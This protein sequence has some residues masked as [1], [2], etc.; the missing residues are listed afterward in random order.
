M[1]TAYNRASADKALQRA[2]WTAD[3]SVDLVGM[4]VGE[5]LTDRANAHPDRV[6]IIG[7]RHGTGEQ[8]RLTYEQLHQEACRVASALERLAERGS[9]IAIWAPNVI[10]WPIIQYGAALAGMVVVAINPAFRER[11]LQYALQ[12]SGSA[13]LLYADADR[14]YDMAAVVRRVAASLPDLTCISLSDS[15][16]WRAQYI[17]DDSLARNTTGDAGVVVMLQ[18]TSG[19]TGNPK[20]VLLRHASLV[21]VAKLTFEALSVPDAAVCLNP[22]PMFHT[23]GC[24][25][26]T[27]GPLWIGGTVILVDRFSPAPVLHALRTEKV[28][29]LFYVPAVLAALLEAQRSSDARAPQLHTIMG[30]ASNVSPALIEAAEQVFGATVI[31]LFGQTELSPVLTATRPEDSRADRLNTVGRPLPQVDCRIVD[32]VSGEVVG[33]GEPG[34][35]CARGYQTLVG[36]LHDPDATARTIDG[37]GFVHTGDLGMM[38][39]RGYLTVTGRLKELIIRGGENIAPVEI[40][41]HLVTHDD[42]VECAVVGLPDNRLGEQVAAV[43]RT[44]RDGDALLKDSLIGYLR[45]RLA[46]FKVPTRWFVVAEFPVTPTGKVRKFELRDAII[47]GN[48]REL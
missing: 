28:S 15:L 46:P 38:D 4:T 33:V 32:P 10:E 40:E 19:T 31:N 25:I 2:S 3:R 44:T 41:S 6:A 16:A 26:A 43:L 18:Y 11:E 13:V 27:L 22:L 20:G 7:V 24:V 47:L 39:S 36:Y 14:D 9:F 35:I 8:V 23:A 21:N 29:V 12:H 48:V 5:L 30:G 34:E 37:E 42:V 17:D 45:N 1:S